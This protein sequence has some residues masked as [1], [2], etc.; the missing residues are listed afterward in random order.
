[1]IVVDPIS[2]PDP[3]H[4][5]SKEPTGFSAQSTRASHAEQPVPLGGVPRALREAAE[6]SGLDPIAQL[7]NEA[8]RYAAEGH[9]RL[10]RERLQMQLCMAPDDG[11]ARLMLAKVFVAGQR[12]QDAIAALDEAQTCGVDVPLSLRTAVEDHL[13]A[14]QLA[15]EEQRTA[16]STREQGEIKAL[17]QEARR[18]RSENAALSGRTA[19]LEHETRRWAWTTAGVSGLSIAF[20]AASLLFGGGSSEA[21]PVEVAAAAAVGGAEVAAAEHEAPVHANPTQ[22]ATGAAAALAQVPGLDG[23]ELEVAVDGSRAVLTGSVVSHKQRRAA[24]EVLKRTPGVDR[25]EADAVVLTART[26]GTSHT[27]GRGDTLSHIAYAY[28]GESKLAS[29]ITKANA[30]VKSTNLRIGQV[31]KIPAV[32]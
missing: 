24:E 9:L 13:R 11:E 30:G 25:V 27:V 16:R 18:L 26:K 32:E 7:Y 15:D 3:G 10:A 6:L 8:L 4:L 28:Y 23:T 14:E 29:A 22:V 20:I 21:D 2:V 19:E 1:M 5:P 31:L 12:W 17:R